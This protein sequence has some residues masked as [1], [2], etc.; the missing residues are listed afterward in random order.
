M[1]T[2]IFTTFRT[3]CFFCLFKFLLHTFNISHSLGSVYDEFFAA[4]PTPPKKMFYSAFTFEE[5]CSLDLCLHSKE[6]NP[7]FPGVVLISLIIFLLYWLCHFLLRLFLRLLFFTSSCYSIMMY[8]G[9]S[10]GVGYF[11]SLWAHWVFAAVWSLYSSSSL[12]YFSHNFFRYVFCHIIPSSSSPNRHIL[13]KIP[14]SGGWIA[15]HFPTG[16]WDGVHF[17]FRFILVYVL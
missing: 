10:E 3:V 11:F 9:I 14:T 2:H 4:L 7:L 15:W 13:F 12:E 1:F 16:H 8:L 5:R 6:A 17:I